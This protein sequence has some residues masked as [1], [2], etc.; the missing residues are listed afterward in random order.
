[1]SQ[2]LLD[3][4]QERAWGVTYRS[5]GEEVTY[6]S[7]GDLRTAV[8]WKSPTPAWVI[9]SQKLPRVSASFNLPSFSNQDH[10]QLW[11]NYRQLGGVAEAQWGSDGRGLSPTPTRGSRVRA[12]MA[13]LCQMPRGQHPTMQLLA[14]LP[15]RLKAPHEQWG[16]LVLRW[17]WF[18]KLRSRKR[19]VEYRSKHTPH[20]SHGVCT[21][22]LILIL[23]SL[24]SF[25]YN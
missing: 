19:E 16:V 7:R 23:L 2:S 8:S 6:R 17:M 12:S 22:G 21:F 14:D 18:Q 3:S 10:A 24:R 13:V 25:M 1:M 11:Q 15:S 4:L 5:V 9:T 20:N